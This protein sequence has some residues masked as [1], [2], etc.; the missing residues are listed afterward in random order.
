MARDYD[1]NLAPL[2]IG[3]F[4]S[5]IAKK[6]YYGREKVVTSFV[7]YYEAGGQLQDA[8][9]LAYA[10]WKTQSEVGFTTE[11][12]ARLETATAIAIL[13]N[14]V[15]LS[16]WTLFDIYSRP[17]L[18]TTLRHEITQNALSVPLGTNTHTLDIGALRDSC[19]A[20]TST[21]QEV[22][23][24]RSMASPL[25]VLRS[26]TVL[27]KQYLLR[28]NAL[29]IMPSASI[30][31]EARSWGD[32]DAFDPLRFTDGAKRS[33]SSFMAFGAA[34][35]LCPGRHFATGEILAIV[36]MVVLRFEMR[37]VA[38]GGEWVAPGKV[39]LRA[40][41]A[42]VAPPDE[43]FEVVFEPVR[44]YE[45]S[46]WDFVVTEGKGRFGLVTG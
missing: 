2:L 24:T 28:A 38:N 36:A 15:V 35:E 27:D 22:L 23:R 12:I 41:A 4:P 14:T 18:L 39:N 40:V 9:S 7:K 31:H 33:P 37:P 42:T 45:G 44:E 19:P 30:N 6:A 3:V 10:R 16:F 25:R 8:S 34:P 21:F 11:T 20:L 46:A 26:D 17:S 29:L 32:D 1:S 5:F 43:A 13:S